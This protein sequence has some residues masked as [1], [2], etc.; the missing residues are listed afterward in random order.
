MDR[1]ILPFTIACLTALVGVAS[2]QDQNSD[3]NKDRGVLDVLQGIVRGERQLRGNV[4]AVHDDEV[5]VRGDDNRTYVVNTSGADESTVQGLKPGQAVSVTARS[6]GQNGVLVASAVKPESSPTKNFQTIEG[7]VESVDGTKITFKTPNGLTLLL[8]LHQ[9][10]GRA[11]NLQP[12][13]PATLTVEQDRDALTVVWIEPRASR[14]GAAS[15]TS[16]TSSA[17][18][19][20]TPPTGSAPSASTLSASP[21]TS[22]VASAGYQRVHGYVQSVA[23]STLAL[24]TDGGQTLTIDTTG[25]SGTA[26]APSDVVSV[27]GKMDGQGR[28]RAELIQKDR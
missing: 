3:K 25:A 9:V 11:P 4:V 7:T 21:S 15:S 6:A 24:K 27:T 23:S 14:A 28:L 8:D 12:N 18:P 5:I 17:S 26:I 13:T 10:I 20:S 19:P 1:R 16:T 2:A 22:G